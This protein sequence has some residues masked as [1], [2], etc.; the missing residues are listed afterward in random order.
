MT[1]KGGEATC[2]ALA[3]HGSSLKVQERLAGVAGRGM[4]PCPEPETRAGLK[5]RRNRRILFRAIR[6]FAF[7]WFAPFFAG[8]AAAVFVQATFAIELAG[9]IVEA[10][11]K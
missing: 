11:S 7:N 9:A 8:I 5:V 3:R 2:E 4:D 10:C 1:R 6:F